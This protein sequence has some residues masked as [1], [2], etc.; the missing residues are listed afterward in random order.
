MVGGSAEPRRAESDCRSSRPGQ[1]RA[2]SCRGGGDLSRNAGYCSG[3][4]LCGDSRRRDCASG[5]VAEASEGEDWLKQN[6][7]TGCDAVQSGA[8]LVARPVHSPP[9]SKEG[10]RPVSQPNPFP[11]SKSSETEANALILRARRNLRKF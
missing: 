1:P 5:L 9:F 10:N 11:P 8:G 4:S 6:C 3:F 2:G 7:A